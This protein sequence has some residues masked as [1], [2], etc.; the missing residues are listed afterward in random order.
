MTYLRYF[1]PLIIEGNKQGI[2]SFV[3]YG[4]N[5]KYNNP[6]ACLDFLTKLSCFYNFELIKLSP[7]S[8]RDPTFF[9]EGEYSQ[10]INCDKKISLTYMTDFRMSFKK[11][12]DNINFCVFPSRFFA[13]LGGFENHPKSVFY[14]SPKYDINFNLDEIFEKYKLSKKDKYI[15]MP[16]PRLRDSTKIDLN[17]ICDIARD[18]G[19]K[20]ITKTRGKDPYKI[21]SDY[22]FMDESWFPHDSMELIYASDMVINFSSTITKEV[23]MLKKRMLNLNIKPFPQRLIKFYECKNFKN[24]NSDFNNLDLIKSNIKDLL[25]KEYD[26]DYYIKKFLSSGSA[27][28][29]II[30]R[31]VKNE[32]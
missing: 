17:S 24:M 7:R 2:K 11:Y 12:I 1:L 16:M 23:L 21:N 14:G 19:Y 26:Y 27:S 31:L 29:R 8:L 20:V 5:Q 18:I 10:H 13:S 6:L 9:V 22:H 30:N 15:F 4:Q 28:K 32:C 25:A 3:Y